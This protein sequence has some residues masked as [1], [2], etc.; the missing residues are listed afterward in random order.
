MRQTFNTLWAKFSQ[1]KDGNT[2]LW[3]WPNPPVIGWAFFRVLAHLA[4][5]PRLR[6]GFDFIAEVF[7]FTWAY[8]EITQGTSYFRRLLGILIM[9]VILAGYFSR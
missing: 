4:S 6:S 2:V 3:Q 5:T 7:L 8:L 1:D 9:I